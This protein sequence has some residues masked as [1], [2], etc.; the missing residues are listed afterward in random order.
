[1]FKNT[2]KVFAS[3]NRRGKIQENFLRIAGIVSNNYNSQYVKI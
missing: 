2:P 1:M 3:Y